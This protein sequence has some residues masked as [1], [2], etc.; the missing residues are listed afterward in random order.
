MTTIGE[1]IA[2]VEAVDGA[3]S[4][5]GLFKFGVIAAIGVVGNVAHSDT[6]I[7]SSGVVALLRFSESPFTLFTSVDDMPPSSANDEVEAPLISGEGLN[8]E[9]DRR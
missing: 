9:H 8:N 5:S 7:A 6:A 4:D 3:S 2:A 1:G